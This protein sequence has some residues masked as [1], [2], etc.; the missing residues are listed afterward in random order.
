MGSAG[1]AAAVLLPS[2]TALAAYQQ[3]PPGT[4][5]TP[6]SVA[7][8]TVTEAILISGLPTTIPLSGAPGDSPTSTVGYNVYTNDPTGYSVNVLATA[9]NLVGT[10]NVANVIPVS[11]LAVAETG[12]TGVG[13]TGATGTPTALGTTAAGVT[14]PSTVLV[15]T[16]TGASADLGDALYTTYSFPAKVPNVPFDIYTDTIDYTATTN[17]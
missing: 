10:T 5:A 16:Q 8:V 12:S 15:H 13:V 4:A 11:D 1:L 14:T 7:T 6:S 9:G 3:P 17:P 2:G